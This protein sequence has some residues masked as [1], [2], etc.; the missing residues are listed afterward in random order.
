MINEIDC[1]LVL[2]NENL[3]ISRDDCALVSD[4]MKKYGINNIVML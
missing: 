1:F 4:L 3:Y 2:G